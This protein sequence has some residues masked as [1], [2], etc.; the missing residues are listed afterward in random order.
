M[1][2]SFNV[3]T[4][5]MEGRRN[6]LVFRRVTNSCVSNKQLLHVLPTTHV[7]CFFVP[8]IP[9]WKTIFYYLLLCNNMYISTNHNLRLSFCNF[10][11]NLVQSSF[12]L[13]IRSTSSPKFLSWWHSVVKISPLCKLFNGLLPNALLKQVLTPQ[14]TN[15][16]VIPIMKMIMTIA[17]M[18]IIN[19]GPSPCRK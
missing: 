10:F 16:A 6:L 4:K 15:L 2:W 1:S 5:F 8:N 11:D 3:L 12:K 17:M 7:L 13:K 9:K 18:M 14:L 19:D